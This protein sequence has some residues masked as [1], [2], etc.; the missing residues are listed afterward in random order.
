[1]GRD[2]ATPPP[3]SFTHNF[4]K[5]NTMYQRNSGL[6]PPP[7]VRDAMAKVEAAQLTNLAQGAAD[8]RAMPRGLTAQQ[9][10]TVLA[11]ARRVKNPSL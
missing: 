7:A 1:M 3:H 8:H 9:R 2:R 11:M 10:K 5:A 6:T 4:L